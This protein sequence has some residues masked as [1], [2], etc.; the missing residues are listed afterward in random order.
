MLADTVSVRR[1]GLNDDRARSSIGFLANGTLD[2]RNA[3]HRGEI[4]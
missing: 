3:A 4:G 2:S 1:A